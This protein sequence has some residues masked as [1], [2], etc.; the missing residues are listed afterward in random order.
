VETT[1]GAS[2]NQ[3]GNSRAEAFRAAKLV[4][5]FQHTLVRILVLPQDLAEGLH[6]PGVRDVLGGGD[7]H[8]LRETGVLA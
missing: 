6:H 7:D 8:G 3:V 2:E 1:P 5:A 4:E